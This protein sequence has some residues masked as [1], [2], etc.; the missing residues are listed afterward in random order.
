M[1]WWGGAVL[2]LFC[3]TNDMDLYCVHTGMSRPHQGGGALGVTCGSPLAPIPG[4]GD[5]GGGGRPNNIIF[6]CGHAHLT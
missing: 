6:T 2:C 3:L 1:K 4:D 5:Q